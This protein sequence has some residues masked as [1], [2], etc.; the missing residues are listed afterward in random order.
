MR[1]LTRRRFGVAALYTW[2]Q[3]RTIDPDMKTHPA[4]NQFKSYKRHPG[5][6][7][8][9][10]IMAYY[11]T[12]FPMWC[13]LGPLSRGPVGEEIHGAAAACSAGAGSARGVGV[14]VPLQGVDGNR[15]QIFVSRRRQRRHIPPQPLQQGYSLCGKRRHAC[16]KWTF[17]CS[18]A[19]GRV[20]MK[21]PLGCRSCPQVRRPNIGIHGN[22]KQN[23]CRGR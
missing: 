14:K 13:T 19:R 21:C 17:C 12:L 15:D 23:P 16:A 22:K 4:S 7:L 9:F 18:I 11:S 20:P 5:G 6:T 8:T 1:S 10:R 3:P 2:L